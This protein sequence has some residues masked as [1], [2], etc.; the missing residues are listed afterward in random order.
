MIGRRTLLGALLI[1]VSAA[2]SNAEERAIVPVSR[3]GS[4]LLISDESLSYLK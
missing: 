2:L 4:E 1:T 3:K